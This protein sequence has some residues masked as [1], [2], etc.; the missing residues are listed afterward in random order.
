VLKVTGA[1]WRAVATTA[2]RPASPRNLNLT[3]DRKIG[4]YTAPGRTLKTGAKLHNVSPELFTLFLV[5]FR[6]Q[7]DIPLI[8]LPCDLELAPCQAIT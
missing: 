2:S 5:V 8:E 1:A 7:R 6:F 4:T 3:R